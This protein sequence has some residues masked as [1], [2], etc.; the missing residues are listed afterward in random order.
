MRKISRVYT[1]RFSSSSFSVSSDQPTTSNDKKGKTV[2]AL[3]SGPRGP[4]SEQ[5]AGLLFYVP[6]FGTVGRNLETT[7]ADADSQ[8]YQ[9]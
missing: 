5:L 4:N 7:Y 8:T 3:D 6:E 1:C 9:S 2:N